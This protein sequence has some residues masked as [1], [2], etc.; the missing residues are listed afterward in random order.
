MTFEV[1]EANAS[2]EQDQFAFKVPGNAAAFKVKRLKF[3]SVEKAEELE[4]DGGA[5]FEFFG[6]KG[7]KQ[8]TALRSLD[9][10]QW[11][12]LVQAWQADSG[13]DLGE[14]GASSTS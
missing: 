8:G 10:E 7:T 1:P 2:K 14:S 9:R 13:V 3:L 4:S 5:L 11:R 6:K 12:A